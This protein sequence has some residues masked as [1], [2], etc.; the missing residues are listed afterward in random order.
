MAILNLFSK[1]KT[2][3]DEELLA[4]FKKSG[5]QQYLAILFD[6]HLS[7]AF[8]ICLKYLKNKDDASDACMELYEKLIKDLQRFDVE[9]FKAWLARTAVNHCLMKLR[10]TKSTEEKSREHEIFLSENVESEQEAHLTKKEEETRIESLH[11]A[12]QELKE[13][14]RKCIELFYFHKH[15]YVEVANMLGMEDKEVKSHIQNGKR[16]L[17][18]I[19]INQQRHSE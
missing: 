10:S 4:R 12:M 6:K 3:H 11:Y 2:Q 15:S 1:K 9:N 16:N 17:K 5:N 14:L 18:Q 8:G 13:D 19:M 7:L